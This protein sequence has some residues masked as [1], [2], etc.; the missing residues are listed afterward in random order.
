MG[1]LNIKIRLNRNDLIKRFKNENNY[2]T[3]VK[4][5][6]NHWKQITLLFQDWPH[7][8][9][10]LTELS[11]AIGAQVE[12]KLHHMSQIDCM[13]YDAFA[14]WFGHVCSEFKKDK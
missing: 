10:G 12:Q 9:I 7:P 13:M 11:K 4:L 8:G 3:H 5:F 1:G 14:M 6:L 2:V